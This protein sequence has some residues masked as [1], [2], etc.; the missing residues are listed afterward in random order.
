MR[1]SFSGFGPSPLGDIFSDWLALTF[2]DLKN[3]KK[4]D[5]RVFMTLGFFLVIH[6]IIV[7]SCLSLSYWIGLIGKIEVNCSKHTTYHS[8]LKLTFLL[9]S[10][11]PIVFK[12]KPSKNPTVFNTK[13]Q[14]HQIS[15]LIYLAT[16][17][18]SY[19]TWLALIFNL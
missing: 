3:N 18:T 15:H 17:P 2:L 7:P 8:K 4:I 12:Y 19:V 6:Q 1:P 16:F 11:N 14:F 9:P 10:R 13:R 5:Q